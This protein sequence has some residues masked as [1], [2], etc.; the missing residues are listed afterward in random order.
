MMGD[1]ANMQMDKVVQRIRAMLKA[2]LAAVY[3]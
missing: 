2:L 1:K 3:I